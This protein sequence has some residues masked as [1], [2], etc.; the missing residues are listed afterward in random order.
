MSVSYSY[1][2][3]TTTQ[4]V[5][6]LD[7]VATNFSSLY[8]MV[9][10]DAGVFKVGKA[11][12]VYVRSVT[13][14]KHWGDISYDE[15]FELYTTQKT[16][17]KLEKSLHFLL[18]EYAVEFT[19]DGDGRTELFELGAIDLALKYLS[20]YTESSSVPIT[21]VKGITP[22][23]EALSTSCHKRPRKVRSK[24]R[25]SDA[26]DLARFSESDFK[27]SR[28][29][30]RLFELLKLRQS[31]GL[32]TTSIESFWDA[33]CIPPSCR[34][35]F[36]AL[37]IR[38]IE[39]AILSITKAT[40]LSVRFTASRSGSRRVTKLEFQFEVSAQTIGGCP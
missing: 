25:P 10:R 13:L 4:P 9:F 20:I 32:Y 6:Y 5:L 28:Y 26:M 3:P 17:F 39:P 27:R 8:I 22:P 11:N 7:D 23:D 38:V 40:P 21:V 24:N 18:A 1:L 36:K 34:K 31:K 19:G 33:L 14:Q 12:D 30:W 16:V 29:A 35:D 15:S 37:R 2:E